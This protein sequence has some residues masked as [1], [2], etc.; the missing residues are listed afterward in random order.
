MTDPYPS[1]TLRPVIVAVAVS[2]MLLLL[3]APLVAAA[4]ALA[5][6]PPGIGISI[7][8]GAVLFVGVM[9]YVMSSSFQW[10]ELGDGVIRGRRLLTRRVVE[11]RVADLVDAKPINT[12]TLGPMQNAILDALLDTR[13]RGYQLVFRDGRRLPLIR[14]DMSGIDPFLGALAE[15]LRAIRDG[16]SAGEA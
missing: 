7:A 12:D 3:V 14:A 4:L 8:V 1:A 6:A 9:G 5:T 13:N 10:V 2:F 15:Q 16:R 11:Y